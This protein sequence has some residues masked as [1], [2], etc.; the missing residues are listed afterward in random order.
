MT[1]TALAMEV[2]ADVGGFE[3]VWPEIRES[4]A[5]GLTLATSAV[6]SFGWGLRPSW[7]SIPH[8]PRYMSPA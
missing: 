8:A 1:N 3:V 2:L 7:T 4:T 6:G 5:I